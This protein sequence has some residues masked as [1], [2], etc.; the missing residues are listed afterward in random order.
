MSV[1][2]AP[3]T[4]RV[5]LSDDDLAAGSQVSSNVLANIATAAAFM[6]VSIAAVLPVAPIFT[7]PVVRPHS[8]ALPALLPRGEYVTVA[9]AAASVAPSPS[10]EVQTSAEQIRALHEA[11]GLTWDQIAKL[12]G[13]SRRALHMWA[14]GGRMN[15]TNYDTLMLLRRVVHEVAGGPTPDDRRAA[16]MAPRTAQGRSIYDLL[17]AENRSSADDVSAEPWWP[18]VYA[19][20]ADSSQV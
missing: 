11:S 9:A 13:T 14:N 8:E 5:T 12:F 18:A 19:E 1:F 3:P 20:S 7:V 4:D 15:A 16:L 6:S 2:H 10:P 17:R